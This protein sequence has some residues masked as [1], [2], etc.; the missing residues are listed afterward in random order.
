MY[1]WV[2]FRVRDN[3]MVN[4]QFPPK[5]G[6]ILGFHQAAF[7]TLPAVALPYC[8]SLFFIPTR[9]VVTPTALPVWGVGTNQIL[10]CPFVLTIYGAKVS[11][12][13]FHPVLL[14]FY[15]F[16]AIIALYAVVRHCSLLR[17]P[18][19]GVLRRCYCSRVRLGLLARGLRVGWGFGVVHSRRM[20]VNAT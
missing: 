9:P 20:C 5:L 19:V 12:R 7:V 14:F 1:R 15:F 6:N 17:V 18:C 8:L 16:T 4:I 3:Q 11:F 2:R 13:A 10:G